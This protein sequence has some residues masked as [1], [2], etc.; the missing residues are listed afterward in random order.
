MGS[1]KRL[2]NRIKYHSTCLLMGQDGN[3]CEALMKDISL[4]GALVEVNC[5]THLHVGDSCTL[6]LGSS[7]SGFP[8]KRP[9]EIVR[10]DSENIGISFLT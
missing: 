6:M 9:V 1:Q 7:S 3:Y 4:G 8:V 10:F 2:H 5:D